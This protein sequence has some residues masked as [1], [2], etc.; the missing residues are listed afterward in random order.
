MATN[1]LWAYIAGV[2]DGEGHLTIAK[3]YDKRQNKQYYYPY[4]RVGNTNIPF[5]TFLKEKTGFGHISS[6]GVKRKPNH[7]PAFYWIIGKYSQVQALLEKVIPYLFIKR[8]LLEFLRIYNEEKRKVLN[9][10][11]WRG[12]KGL[13]GRPHWASYTS[14]QEE[15][16]NELRGLNKR[17]RKS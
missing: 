12:Y 17:G 4:I 14:R 7:K 10:I 16:Y 13:R 5:L 11:N 6:V 2:V 9:S 1:K 3:E 15:I 8:R